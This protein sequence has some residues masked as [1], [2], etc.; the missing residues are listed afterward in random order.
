MRSKQ[1]DFE[2]N[3]LVKA[4]NEAAHIEELETARKNLK[5]L[6]TYQAQVEK[7]QELQTKLPKKSES[8]V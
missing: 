7:V 5:T 2:S 6:D 3:R 4:K 1:A 8:H